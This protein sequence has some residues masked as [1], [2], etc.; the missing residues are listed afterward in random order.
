[1]A[2]LQGFCWF[3]ACLA[4]GGGDNPTQSNVNELF[5]WSGMPQP[6]SLRLPRQPEG[7]GQPS[8]RSGAVARRAD[9]PVATLRIW[10]Q[11][12][13]AVAPTTSDSGHRLYSA[14]DIE[15]VVLL[16]QLTTQGHGIGSLARLDLGQLQALAAALPTPVADADADSRHTPGWHQQPL[17]L[18]VVGQAMA[19]RL[20]RAA[21]LR[22]WG[23]VPVVLGVYASLAEA[24]QA[25]Q[26]AEAT[27]APGHGSAPPDLL[28]WQAAGLH[29]HSVGELAAATDA[30]G[31]RQ[32]AVAY[33]FAGASTKRQL[34][35][36]GVALIQE[37]SDDEALG[38]WLS[39]LEAN[40]LRASSDSPPTAA[41][42]GDP[43]APGALGLTS[44]PAPARRFDDAALTAFAGL[45]STVA[46]ECPKHLADLL[47]Q[48]ASFE[49][50][51]ADCQ[52][53]SPADAALHG[54]LHRV[55]GAARVLLETALERV[56]VEEGLHLPEPL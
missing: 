7:P 18:V 21:I 54:Y 29:G 8:F 36:A 52:H 4:F 42:V 28:L 41:R 55:A 16:R 17:R 13:Q 48:V 22:R 10:E 39:A 49:A 9:M 20:R 11:R 6:K 53:R 47:I 56:A 45:P 44:S 37:P 40:L 5:F 2:C 32:T 35:D 27:G 34:L 1:M 31:P 46:C 15:R 23:R 33:R 38:H 51:S 50:Y 24:V 43:W 25:A 19:H 30:L 12:Y 26:A 14:A 3:A